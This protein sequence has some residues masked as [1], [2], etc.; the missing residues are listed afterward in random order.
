MTQANPSKKPHSISNPAASVSSPAQP[1][2]TA[3]QETRTVKPQDV[4]NWP[5]KPRVLSSDK[6]A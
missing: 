2:H 1:N 3:D 5:H 6:M 4:W